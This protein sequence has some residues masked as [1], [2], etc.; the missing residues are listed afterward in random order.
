MKKDIKDVENFWNNNPLWTGESKF[1]PG[2][3]EFFD[4]HRSVY[5][6][7]CFGGSFDKRFLPPYQ[8]KNICLHHLLNYYY[9]NQEQSTFVAHF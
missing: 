9:L 4:E 1:K 8:D 7:D 2:T 3:K 5:I 6:N